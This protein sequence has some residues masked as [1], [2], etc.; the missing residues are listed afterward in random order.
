MLGLR[1]CARAFS[2]CGERGPLFIAVRGPLTTTASLAADHRLQTRG[3]SS[4]GSRAQ[5]LC[6]MWDPPRP[7]L[8]PVSP[9]LAGRLSTT[10]P[11]GKPPNNILIL[12]TYSQHMQ[13]TCLRHS[14][15]FTG[16][17]LIVVGFDHSLKT[18]CTMIVATALSYRQLTFPNFFLFLKPPYITPKLPLTLNKLWIVS[19][20]WVNSHPTRILFT[21]LL[22]N[23]STWLSFLHEVILASLCLLQE[24][25][26]LEGI[27]GKVL[28]K[29][30]DFPFLMHRKKWL[31]KLLSSLC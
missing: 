14:V 7:G 5:L 24:S 27:R 18:S 3:L 20:I 12:H 19:L 22:F 25:W 17:L 21:F 29:R 13:T 28:E 6:G 10:A 2:S 11:P 9:A 30:P 8:E 1:F 15:L 16:I 23:L 26:T 31:K 4:C